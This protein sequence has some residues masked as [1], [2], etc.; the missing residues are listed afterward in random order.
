MPADPYWTRNGA[1][2]PPDY[3]AP[4]EWFRRIFGPDLTN[5]DHS[6]TPH[7]DNAGG[8]REGMEEHSARHLRQG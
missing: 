7:L 8:H 4:P 3:T 2:F 1:R 5:A 6:F